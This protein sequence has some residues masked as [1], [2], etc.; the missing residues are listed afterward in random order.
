MY[1]GGYLLQCILIMLYTYN[2]VYKI[3]YIYI[4]WNVCCKR[5]LLPDGLR[6]GASRE[7]PGGELGSGMGVSEDCV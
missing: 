4:C 2:Y 1:V 6:P 5:G 7:S 3:I